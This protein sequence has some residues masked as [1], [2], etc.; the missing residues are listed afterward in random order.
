[1]R[2]KEQS[3]PTKSGLKEKGSSMKAIVLFF[4]LTGLLCN[5][6]FSQPTKRVKFQRGRSSAVVNGSV[7]GSGKMAYVVEAR[8]GQKMNLSITK[9]AGF[10]LSG[11]DGPLEGGKIVSKSQQELSENGDYE[12]EVS[13]L[14]NRSVSYALEIVIR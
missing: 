14:S 6:G 7:S 13:S 2:L 11:P 12:I 8:K 10:R 3:S 4:L 5:S 9:G 1:M